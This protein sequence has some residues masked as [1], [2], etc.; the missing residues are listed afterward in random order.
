[1][2]E[3]PILD[4]ETCQSKQ[5]TSTQTSARALLQKLLNNL[6]LGVVAVVFSHHCTELSKL[7]EEAVLVLRVA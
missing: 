6:R 5:R 4:D 3:I 7:S 1:M 2:R